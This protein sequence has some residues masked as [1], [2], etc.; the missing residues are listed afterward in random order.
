MIN[1]NFVIFY[2]NNQFIITYKNWIQAKN[3]YKLDWVLSTLVNNCKDKL[4]Y[5]KMNL[6][7]DGRKTN[8]FDSGIRG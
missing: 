8:K 6:K 2:Y 1:P 5:K 4:K 3:I 7:K